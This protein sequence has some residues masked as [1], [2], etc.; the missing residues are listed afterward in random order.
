MEMKW[1]QDGDEMETRWRRAR[2][3]SDPM[4]EPT[5]TRGCRTRRRQR[6]PR[7]F[8]FLPSFFP[9]APR[10]SDHHTPPH[11]GGASIGSVR[12][13]HRKSINKNV[14]D[15]ATA[16]VHPVRW[17]AIQVPWFCSHRDPPV[18][19]SPACD[20]VHGVADAHLSGQTSG[21]SDASWICAGGTAPNRAHFL[22]LDSDPGRSGP[23]DVWLWRVFPDAPGR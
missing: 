9:S 2:D 11:H 5:P 19:S 3:R 16:H 4:I 6:R 23:A 13:N 22:R 7:C 15:C 1:R 12:F 18:R 8:P 21:S 17:A 20:A 14:S 10:P